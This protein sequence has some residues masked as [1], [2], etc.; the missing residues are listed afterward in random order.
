M[1]VI[2][3]T[4]TS[5]REM[6]ST[7]RIAVLCAVLLLIALLLSCFANCHDH[8]L[9]SASLGG[10]RPPNY[11]V[12][13]TLEAPV[14]TFMPVERQL[15]GLFLPQLMLGSLVPIAVLVGIGL[16]LAKLL[17]IGLW[18]LKSGGI[19]GYPGQGG[20]GIGGYPGYGGGYGGY[21]G[22]GQFG[23]GGYGASGWRADQGYGRSLLDSNGLPVS[24]FIASSVMKLVKHVSN[25]LAKY[26][27]YG[28]S[29]KGPE[30]K[31]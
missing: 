1:L 13:Q 17:A 25:A 6:M 19:G 22:Y 28:P 23:G 18:T 2:R 29:D 5:N 7:S 30:K 8:G 11:T 12:G 26:D 9:K 31:A 20:F 10:K 3:A 14:P 4:V 27:K 15:E 24:P 16:I 21:G